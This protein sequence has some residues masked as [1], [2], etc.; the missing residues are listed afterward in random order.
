MTSRLMAVRKSDNDTRYYVGG[1]RVSRPTFYALDS[2]K[3]KSCFQ[4]IDKGARWFHYHEQE[5]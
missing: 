5:L 4:T 3:P 1:C 2:G